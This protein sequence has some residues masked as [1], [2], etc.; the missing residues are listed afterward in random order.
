MGY[1][2]VGWGGT[3]KHLVEFIGEFL[4]KRLRGLG[5][6]YVLYLIIIEYM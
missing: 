4:G 3:Q 2:A 6:I 1:I 5:E